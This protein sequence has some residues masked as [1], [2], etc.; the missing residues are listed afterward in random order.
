MLRAALALIL[1]T[2]L[3]SQADAENTTPAQNWNVVAIVPT[4]PMTK[5]P[6]A[7]QVQEPYCEYGV[8]PCGG[9]CLEESGK[10][11]DCPQNALPCYQRGQ[12]CICEVASMCRPK[13]KQ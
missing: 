10:R 9:T 7:L 13:K 5:P 6:E 4:R 2:C 12:H 3:V 11:W 1:V 8:G